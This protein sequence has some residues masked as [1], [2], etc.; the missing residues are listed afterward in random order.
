MIPDS[1]APGIVMRAPDKTSARESGDEAN[2]GHLVI[3]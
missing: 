1:L 3:F 2:L